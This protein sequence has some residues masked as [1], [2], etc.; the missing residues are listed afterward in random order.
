MKRQLR[1][2]YFGTYR[3]DY[4]RNPIMIERLR[5][6]GMEVVECHSQ[7][8]TG[9][10]DRVDKASGGWKRPRFL[11]RV[12]SAYARLIVRYLRVGEY[13]VMI[14]GYP[15]QFDVYLARM[16][17]WLR[18]KPLVLDVLMSL[19]L[20]ATERGLQ[21]SSPFT[22][23]M[24]RW[25]ETIAYRLPDRL[26]MDTPAYVAY[27]EET[28]GLAAERFC[29]VPLGADDRVYYPS[30]E[31]R[32]RAGDTKVVFY[33]SFIPLH[34][35]QYI[36]E[37]ADILRDEP[38]IEFELVGRGPEKAAIE[39][40][41]AQRGLT[42]VRFVEWIPKE[43]LTAYVASA[44]ICLGVFGTTQQSMCTIQNKIYEC[45]AMRKPLVTGDAPLMR[46]AFVHGEHLYL[47]ERASG[48]AIADAIVALRND[49]QL[50]Q[51]LAER[52]YAL[53]QAAYTIDRTSELL[54]ACLYRLC[55]VA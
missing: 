25:F 11:W 55:A 45:L 34:G 13:D 15:G 33:G 54:E 32:E 4:A 42:N 2:C 37:A 20:I 26:I 40:A 39:A 18:R 19:Y 44:D 23:R 38:G 36:V 22:V 8:W 14:L 10:E 28:Y 52:G 46:S 35:V 53:F 30:A 49:E 51:H 48:R 41:V 7:L 27:M 21:G 50:R 31:G 9:T 47:C 29:L 6:R 1:V 24:I 17:T 5:R 43:E 12:V 3:A 16:L